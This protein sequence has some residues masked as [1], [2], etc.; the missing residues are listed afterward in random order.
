[1]LTILR[2]DHSLRLPQC[3]RVL[4]VVRS[5]MGSVTRHSPQ[6]KMP[7]AYSALT[8]YKELARLKYVQAEQGGK[9]E[10]QVLLWA[11]IKCHHICRVSTPS[12]FAHD[13]CHAK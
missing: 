9:S 12:R 13:A 7:N 6:E 5:S 11:A 4:V 8:P 2:D 10:R 1:M 3:E